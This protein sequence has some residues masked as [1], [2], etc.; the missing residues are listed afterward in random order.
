M[1]QKMAHVNEQVMAVDA[2]WEI[3][4]CDGCGDQLDHEYTVIVK[5]NGIEGYGGEDFKKEICLSCFIGIARRMGISEKE[6]AKIIAWSKEDQ[7]DLL[8]DKYHQTTEPQVPKGI[9]VE[10]ING[11]MQKKFAERKAYAEGK[12][13]DIP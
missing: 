8:A 1:K 4:L 5:G 12:D 7:K 10:R 9:V 13:V 11:R 3:L 2:S 6:A